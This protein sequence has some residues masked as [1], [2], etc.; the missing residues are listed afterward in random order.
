MTQPQ[1]ILAVLRIMEEQRL[2]PAYFT[3]QASSGKGFILSLLAD[4]LLT[5]LQSPKAQALTTKLEQR[6]KVSIHLLTPE[7]ME[8]RFSV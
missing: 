4:W 1:P 5:S 8:S 7:R 6:R 3:N 2:P